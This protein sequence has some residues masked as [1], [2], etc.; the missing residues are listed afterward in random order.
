MSVRVP[1]RPA[2]DRNQR[3]AEIEARIAES[4]RELA[5]LY[6]L[7]GH[8]LAAVPR[9]G[10]A[11]LTTDAPSESVQP[12]TTHSPAKRLIRTGRDVL[13]HVWR[14]PTALF[15]DVERYF[16]RS[17]HQPQQWATST[18]GRVAVEDRLQDVWPLNVEIR[19]GL[20]PTLNV[21]L[22][23]L[24]KQDLT[25]GPNTALNLTYRLAARGVP[26]RYIATD[27]ELDSDAS[28]LHAHLRAVSGIEDAID[29]VQFISGRNRGCSLVLGADDVLCGTAWWTAQMIKEI[30]PRFR[31]QRF[32]YLIQDFEPAMYAWSTKQAL[33]LETYGLDFHGIICGRLLADFL[34]SER[35]GRF[36]EPGFLASCATFEPA[37]DP[38]RFAPRFDRLARRK[39][40]LLFYA[41]PQAPRNLFEMGLVA[42]KQAAARGAFPAAEWELGFIG[43]D[44]MPT[45]D[46]GGGVLIKSHP[47][48]DYQSYARLLQSAD[49]GLS[50]MLSP[51][52]SYPPLEMAACGATVVTNTFAVKTAAR[53]GA[54]STNLLP[55]E[56][57]VEDIVAGLLAAVERAD[58]LPERFA[59]AMLDVPPDWDAALDPV[60]PRILDMWNACRGR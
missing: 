5:E 36:S 21:L 32:L 48:R 24:R 31:S 28:F 33:A 17:K 20:A 49:V 59:G 23:S 19:T 10:I 60:L 40:Q 37:V 30:Q 38:H 11:D 12:P 46:L 39:K 2:P 57:C 35:V 41:R 45:A 18:S 44:E 50:L 34:A 43:G 29:N 55:V 7:R 3:A 4:R 14:S 51:H 54:I 1:N 22:P 25:G 16:A 42:L 8:E 47:W 53:L 15:A 52:T 56:P 58:Q 27:Q 13:R 26:V 9:P 6:A